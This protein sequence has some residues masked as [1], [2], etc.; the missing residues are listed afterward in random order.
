MISYSKTT[1]KNGLEIITAPINHT[2]TVSV[3]FLIGAG[4][5]HES[6]AQNGLSHFLEHMFFKGTKKRPTS[7][8]ISRE[9][10]AV[11]ANFNAFTAEEYTGFYVRVEKT[12]FQLALDILSDIIFNSKF[13]NP[14]INKEKGVILEELN[15]YR[16]IPQRHVQDLA[17]ELLYGNTSLGRSTVGTKKTITSF[18]HQDFVSYRDDFYAPSNM[19]V[20]IAGAGSQENWLKAVKNQLGH[21]KKTKMK[22]YQ[23]VKNSQK[24]PELSLEYKKTDQTHLVLGFKSFSR[25]DPRQ[26]VLQ[27]I[28]NILGD[29]MS[30]RLFTEIREKRGLAYYVS[31]DIWQFH[32]TGAIQAALGADTKRAEEAIKVVLEEFKQIKEKGVTVGELKQAKENFKGRLYLELEE[33]FAQAEF[34]AEQQLLKGK[35]KTPE[36]IL[37]EIYKVSSSDIIKVAREIFKEENLNLTIIGPYKNTQRFNR[38][39]EI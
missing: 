20:A 4:S 3:L 25:T 8:D 1:L 30:S 19:L 2:N 35:I 11:G 33:S 7:L 24:R 26:P 13:S 31:S 5:R 29:T 15:M 17:K 32:E 10:D 22:T 37:K 21:L 18:A 39:L 9:L 38:L 12:H 28:N 36:E 16:D 27:L 34:L 6:A 23:E 14:E